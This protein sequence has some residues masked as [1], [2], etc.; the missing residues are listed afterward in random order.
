MQLQKFPEININ[1]ISEK[2][3]VQDY[4][5]KYTPKPGGY[6]KF[7]MLN[8]TKNPNP[9]AI[10]GK[11]DIRYPYV[12]LP[13]RAKIKDPETSYPVEIG[14]V[15]EVEASGKAVKRHGVLE[16]PQENRGFFVIHENIIEEIEKLPAI[17]LMNE[18]A[19]NPFR[20]ESVTPLYEIVDEVA[21][22]KLRTSK[23]NLKNDMME[24][25]ALMDQEERRELY[26]AMGGD[27]DADPFVIEDAL[28]E[29]CE[30]DPE[31]FKALVYNKEKSIRAIVKRALDKNVITYNPQT[32]QYSFTKSKENIF[33]H[34]R[35][36]GVEPIQLFAQ[37]INS[38]A[39][40]GHIMKQLKL[41]VAG[42]KK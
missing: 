2:G 10:K 8:G 33:T 15:L 3:K 36:E 9:D 13:L 16:V 7:R 30:A 20:D 35:K 42:D 14:H 5:N 18:C 40:G 25:I 4:L 12:Q 17:L 37:F 39:N 11:N 6:V 1:K 32:C 28:Q 34:E 41:L 26:A 27:Y 22:A 38:A 23:R 29:S 24:Y 21:N 31:K 19:D